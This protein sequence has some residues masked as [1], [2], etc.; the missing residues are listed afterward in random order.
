MI[1]FAAVFTK[2]LWFLAGMFLTISYFAYFGAM[3]INLTPNQEVAAV[4]STTFYSFFNLFCGFLIPRP[5]SCAVQIDRTA[6]ILSSARPVPR[7]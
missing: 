7:V 1:G 6:Q 3:C 2:F 4:F 5:V